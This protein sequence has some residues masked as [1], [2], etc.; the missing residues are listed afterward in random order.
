[1]GKG[2]H[3]LARA[4]IPELGGF[5]VACRENSSAVGTER[6]VVDL[7]LM[8]KGGQELARSR[9]PEIGSVIFRACRQH[10]CTVRAKRRVKEPTAM[11][12]TEMF[13]GSDELA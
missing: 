12:K 9:I 6:S 5:V 13:K 8:V 4:R 7:I 11:I 3:K 1:M 2:G 10:S